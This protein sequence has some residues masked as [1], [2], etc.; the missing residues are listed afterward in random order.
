MNSTSSSSASGSA[1]VLLVMT[2]QR[3]NLKRGRSWEALPAKSVV[4]LAEI[5]FASGI[6]VLSSSLGLPAEDFLRS[7]P[8]VPSKAIS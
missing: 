7:T 4:N 6:G 2:P 8:D 3:G 5:S 1:D